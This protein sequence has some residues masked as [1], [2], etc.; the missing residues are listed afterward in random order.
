MRWWNDIWLNEG[1][2]SFIEYYGTDNYAKEWRMV[3]DKLI[4]SILVM[5]TFNVPWLLIHKLEFIMIIYL[6]IVGTICK[7]RFEISS[8]N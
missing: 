6:I 4:I 2:A 8:Q 3:S 5:Y 1:F 7:S